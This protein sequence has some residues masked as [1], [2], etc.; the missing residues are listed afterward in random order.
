MKYILLCAGEGRRMFPFTVLK[1]KCML[2]VNEKEILQYHLEN[3]KKNDMKLSIVCGYRRDALD[4]INIKKYIN[5]N[6]ENT[7][8]IESLLKA[9][10]EFNEDLIVAYGDIIYKEEILSKLKKENGDF[11]VTVDKH[12][13]D[14]WLDR[15]GKVNY[16]IESL[17]LNIDGAINELGRTN[18]K[19]DEI[20]GRYVGLLKFS[21]NGLNVIEEIYNSNPKWKML[22][23][24]D[25]LQ[26]IIN[27]GYKVNSFII[28]GG[29]L[30]FDTKHDYTQY[31]NCDINEL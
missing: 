11:V 2:K 30:E 12:W 19:V 6:Y 16:D 10:D 9:K 14:Y 17:S 18:V 31:R 28:E 3:A 24:T 25:L 22:Y 27:L 21:K 5:E 4:N 20:D 13:K 26:E 15:Y 7:N 29:W 8:M 23:M 1:P